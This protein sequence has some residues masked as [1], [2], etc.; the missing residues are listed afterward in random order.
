L[1]GRKFIGEKTSSET[2]LIPTS[3]CSC[4]N[5]RRAEDYYSRRLLMRMRMF[6]R[7]SVS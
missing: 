7:Y 2:V 3:Q 4:V 6:R 5:A 1:I